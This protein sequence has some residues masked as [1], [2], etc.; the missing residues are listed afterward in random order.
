MSPHGSGVRVKWERTGLTAS[1]YHPQANRPPRRWYLRCGRQVFVERP[2]DQKFLNSISIRHIANSI[3]T[4]GTVRCDAR[5]AATCACEPQCARE[6]ADV[7]SEVN[8][9]PRRVGLGHPVWRPGWRPEA[10]GGSRVRCTR[11]PGWARNRPRRPQWDRRT[12][13]WQGI[14]NTTVNFTFQFLQHKFQILSQF[15]CSLLTHRT[16]LTSPTAR[17]SQY[18]QYPRYAQ[19]RRPPHDSPTVGGP[20]GHAHTPRQPTHAAASLRVH[21]V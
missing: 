21:A 8:R 13:G 9:C 2:R 17:Y 1:T 20:V 11:R 7:I 3:R 15:L 6:A 14:M 5:N 16:V 10:P 19:R 18:S 12:L 4:H